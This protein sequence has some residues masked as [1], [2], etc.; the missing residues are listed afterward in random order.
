MKLTF[1]KL[2]LQYDQSIYLLK[3]GRKSFLVWIYTYYIDFLLYLCIGSVF[4]SLK[5][6]SV[7]TLVYD[8][9]VPCLKAECML[10]IR[11][12]LT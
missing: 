1:P 7:S 6:L 4:L 9:Y 3:S 12:V 8:G 11:K 5:T 10:Y 2:M